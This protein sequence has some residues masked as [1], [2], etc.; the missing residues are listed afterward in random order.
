MDANKSAQPGEREL[1]KLEREYQQM[2][3]DMKEFKSTMDS[4]DRENKF[5]LSNAKKK[6]KAYVMAKQGK[7]GHRSDDSDGEKGKDQ[8]F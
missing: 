4:K 3:R 2:E 8:G 6:Y 1:S 5:Y 7:E